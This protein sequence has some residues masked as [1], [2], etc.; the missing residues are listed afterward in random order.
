MRF[1][2]CL[3]G[4]AALAI[5][6]ACGAYALTL[7]SSMAA[8]TPPSQASFD[9]VTVE[10]GAILAA[11]A[12]CT[13]C[14]T[15]PGGEPF[16][17]GLPLKTPFGTLY[18]TNITPEETTGVGSWSLEAFKRAMREGVDRQGDYLYPAFPYT[19]YNHVADDDLAALYAFLMT[20]RP[21][22]AT[23]PPND[24]IPPLGFRPLLAGWNLLFL[25]E[26]PFAP[27]EDQSA[28]WNRGAYLVEGLGH[29]GLCHTPLNLA[30][31]EK[32]S[33]TFA[34][35][36]AEGWTAPPLDASNPN[37]AR[38]SVDRLTAYLR[39]GLDAEHG[40][41]AGPMGPVTHG[42]STVPEGEV[43]AIAVYITSKMETGE[44]AQQHGESLPAA[45][46]LDNAEEAAATHQAGAAI[47]AG[48]CAGCHGTGA[49]MSSDG[50]PSLAL[51]TDL[52]ADD[53]RNTIQTIL[54]GIPELAGQK[55]PLM[56]S[57]AGVFSDRDVA[58]VTAYLRV[59]FTD[60][61]A[62]PNLH[63]AVV[64]ARNEGEKP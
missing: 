20:R 42:L 39:S 33:K 55:R 13:V 44:S 1:R 60:Q 63:D 15:A 17:G 38:W 14:H 40:V 47:F 5:L 22:K 57:F 16:A 18:S 26:A 11:I 35:G 58:E 53:P 41:A 10:K 4:G 52:A 6:G 59:R 8:I 19:H 56:P 54:Q 34:G 9:K 31:A 48:A 21:V 37:A 29:C 46:P 50:R 51:T 27:A 3:L 49:P 25:D 2:T 30:G 32:T 45:K 24:L 23:P 28:E 7:R 62:W 61:P 36:V 12:D 64:E 43:R